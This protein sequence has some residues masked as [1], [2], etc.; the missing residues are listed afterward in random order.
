VLS[1]HLKTLP[2]QKQRGQDQ[3][4]RLVDVPETLLLYLLEF[5]FLMRTLSQ[6]REVNREVENL[7]IKARPLLH[8]VGMVL[9]AAAIVS[10]IM[11]VGNE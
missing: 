7:F 1:G 8:C 6:E 11:S 3:C 5:F 2:R 10:V 4:P 9:H